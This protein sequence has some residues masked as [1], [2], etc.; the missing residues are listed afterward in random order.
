MG[1]YDIN[2]LG[3]VSKSKFYFRNTELKDSH[4]DPHRVYFKLLRLFIHAYYFTM[5]KNNDCL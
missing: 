3:I 5:N 4:T 2:K 1:F